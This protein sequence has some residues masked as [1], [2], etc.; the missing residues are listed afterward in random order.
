MK[1]AIVIL[2]WNGVTLLKQFLPSVVANSE[3]V[4]IYVI[5]NA[6]E[7]NSVDFI[8]SNFPEIELIHLEKNLGYAGGYNE[9]LKTIKADLIC[10]MNNDIK[11][12]Q[13]W[14]QPVL[15]AFEQN[16]DLGAAQP[17]LLDL[18]RPDYFE[19]AGAA[20]GYI[21]KYGFPFCR[22]RLFEN[23]EQDKGQYDDNSDIFWA[24]GA[25]LFIRRELFDRLGGFDTRFF[26]HM[27]E[28][29]LCWRLYHKGYA[30]KHIYQS[31]V[32]HL[33]GGTLSHSSPRKTFL[34]F[35][36]SLY[37]LYKNLPAKYRFKIIFTRLILDGIAA[38][39]FFFEAQPA[40]SLAVLKAHLS[41]Y[42]SFSKLDPVENVADRPN[43][44]YYTPSVVWSYFLKGK[45]TFDRL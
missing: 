2:N 26:A 36:N 37:M 7:D 5:D 45:K 20:G 14:L 15:D 6:S 38:V 11:V 44:Y 1:T 29:D 41:Y 42:G 28:V 4:S 43:K 24:S 10:L 35:R 23:L 8:T 40:H 22:G 13:G 25:C 21:D 17:T 3:S 27:E 30:V 16:E 39:K 19:Y 18:N 34:N 33:G 31:K 32:Y 12:E 9:G